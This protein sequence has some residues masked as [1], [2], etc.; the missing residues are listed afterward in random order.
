[1]RYLYFLLALLVFASFALAQQA[2]PAEGVGLGN[3]HLSP[4][5]TASN[6]PSMSPDQNSVMTDTNGSVTGDK[7]IPAFAGAPS[8]AAETRMN[9]VGTTSTSA[10]VS[11]TAARREAYGLEQSGQ[12]QP[13]S[14]QGTG[15]NAQSSVPRQ[16][17]QNA[18]SSNT[19]SPKQQR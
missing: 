2:P 19:S 18:Q 1:M 10:W 14:G 4:N 15:A 16:M 3:S 8:A 5:G 11:S 6:V 9:S 17:K 13:V 12:Q 7:G